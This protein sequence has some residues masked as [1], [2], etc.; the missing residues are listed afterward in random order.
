M[1]YFKECKDDVFVYATQMNQGNYT[2]KYI[3]Q[4]YYDIALDYL[5]IH[6]ANKAFKA[7]PFLIVMLVFFNLII[8][9]LF[10]SYEY[11]HRI[12]YVY[13]VA[14]PKDFCS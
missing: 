6:H 13:C 14:S 4:N 12:F 8:I 5:T 2:R 7:F 11:F 10:E 9:V 1:T 3:Y